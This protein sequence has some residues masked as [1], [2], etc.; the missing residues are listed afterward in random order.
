[1]FRRGFRPMKQ[2]R[3]MVKKS[4]AIEKRDAEVNYHAYNGQPAVPRGSLV[5]GKGLLPI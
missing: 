2:W 4:A 1:M 5:P 3:M